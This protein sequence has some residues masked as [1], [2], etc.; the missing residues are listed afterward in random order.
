MAAQL[1]YTY[2]LPKGVA[3]EKFD[4]SF[5]EVVTRRNQEEDGVL[6]FGM[7]VQ[8]GDSPGVS[9]KVP[10]TG[11]TAA[12]MDG[13]AIRTS[14]TEQDMQGRVLVRGGASVNVMKRGKVWSRICSDAQPVY[15]QTAYVVVDGDEA[16]TFTSASAAANAYFKCESTESGAKEVVADST[17]SPTSSQI[18]AAAVTPVQSG[19]TPAVGDYVVSKQLHGATVDMGAKF[20][21]A[22]DMEN[23]VAVIEIR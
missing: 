8:K 7:A 15:G 4:I 1:Q 20:G 17:A 14:A 18:K 19:Y 16:G 12:D 21:N 11:A 5:D 10:V 9:V 2:S 23:G 22:A 6:K 13:I 3:G